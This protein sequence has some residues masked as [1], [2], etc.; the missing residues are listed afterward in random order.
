MRG[1]AKA[2]WD[3]S[4]DFKQ[5][6]FHLRKGVTFHTGRPFTSDDVKYNL[7]RVRQPNVG[8]QLTNM[9]KWFSGIDTP[10]LISSSCST[11]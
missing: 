9:S 11:W 4:K 2:S 7:L 6:T 5:L 3:V 8:T 1:G 10:C